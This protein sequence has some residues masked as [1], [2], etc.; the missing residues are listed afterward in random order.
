[1]LMPPRLCP[2]LNWRRICYAF[3]PHQP[4]TPTPNGP[5]HRLDPVCSSTITGSRP[6]LR[7]KRACRYRQAVGLNNLFGFLKNFQMFRFSASF[8]RLALGAAAALAAIS[9]SPGSAQAF[10]VNVGGVQYDVTTFIGSYNDNSSKFALPPAPGGMP[11][12]GSQSTASQ[13]AAAVRD[14]LGFWNNGVT[15]Y[16][17]IAPLFGWSATG[18]GGIIWLEA[19]GNPAFFANPALSGASYPYGVNEWAY[20]S[21]VNLPS[22]PVP[23]PLPL[24]GAAAAFGFS[25]KLRK[26]TKRSTNAVSTNYSL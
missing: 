22:V 10:V 4:N 15:C 1:M 24:L 19:Y 26:R 21:V 3:S 5:G 17:C 18:P 9:L 2:W 8:P 7:P 14:N 11:W 12:W 13:F 20:A 25:R 6:W 16:A 23:G